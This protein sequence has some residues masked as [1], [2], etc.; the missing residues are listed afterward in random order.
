MEIRRFAVG[1]IQTNCY[2]VFD[3]EKEAFIVDPGEI[4]HVMLRLIKEQDLKPR[5][6]ILTHGHGDHTGGIDELKAQFPEIKLLAC[7]AE[8]KLLSDSHMSYGKPG[9]AADVWVKDGETL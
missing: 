9:I 3:E 4:S 5:Y 8:K 7:E 2:L 6:I 1:P